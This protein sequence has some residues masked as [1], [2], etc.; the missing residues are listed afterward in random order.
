MTREKFIEKFIDSTWEI[1]KDD[2]Y[3][4]TDVRTISKK[5]HPTLQCH[6]E[7]FMSISSD[8]EI[9]VRIPY[10]IITDI[11]FVEGVFIEF[12]YGCVSL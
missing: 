4:Y 8:G 2:R 12:G 1:K 6:E 5:G 7:E 9:W 3:F 10:N 11:F